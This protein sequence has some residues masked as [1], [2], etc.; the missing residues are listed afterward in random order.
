[1]DN[2]SRATRAH[3]MSRIKGKNTQPE[4]A[5][6]R[7]LWGV[8]LRGYRLHGRLPGTPD[9]VY[10]RIR[11]AVFVDG[12]FWHGCPRHFRIPSDNRQYWFAKI[13]RNRRRDRRHARS[14]RAQGWCVLR[15]WEH[16]L[17]SPTDRVRTLRRVE[18]A[19]ARSHARSAISS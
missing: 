8:G 9:L 11:L 6:R 7:L 19:I 3:V 2:I 18:V 1:M 5:L 14:L 13:E 12:C 15:V 16:G 17:R 4:L 10:S